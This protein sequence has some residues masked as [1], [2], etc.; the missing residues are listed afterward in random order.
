MA[1][2]RTF[3][4]LLSLQSASQQPKASTRIKLLV[5]TK[6]SPFP[7]SDRREFLASVAGGVVATSWSANAQAATYLEPGEFRGA[8]SVDFNSNLP[9]FVTLPSGVR[10]LDIKEGKGE[11]VTEGKAVSC[12]W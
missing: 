3:G 4:T 11:E 1:F 8:Q 2:A 9:P 5:M 6:E 12:Q 10:I 7:V